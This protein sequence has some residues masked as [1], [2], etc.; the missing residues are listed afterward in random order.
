MRVLLVVFWLGCWSAFAQQPAPPPPAETT[1]AQEASPTADAR[2][3]EL[4]LIGKTNTAAGESRRNENVQFNLVDNNALKELN[5]RL[6]AT[7][8]IVK[9]SS[10]GARLLQRR[11]RQPAFAGAARSRFPR[12]ISW[13]S[14]GDAPEQHFQ[15]AIVFPGWRRQARAR[16]RLRLPC[17]R[18]ALARR[19]PVSGGRPEEGGR[20]RERQCARAQGRRTHSAHHR[21]GDPRHRR[22]FPGGLSGGASQSHRH[23]S[24]HV[25]HQLAADHRP[26]QRRR[27]AGPAPGHARPLE[28]ALPVHQPARGGV[29]TGGG[30]ESE[31][32]HPCPHRARHLGAPVEPGNH[33]GRLGGLRPDRRRCWRR[34][35]TRSARWFR[36]RGWNRSGRWR[37]SPS[38]GK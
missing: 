35:R 36:S 7:A 4:N 9:D 10:P 18:A 26:E 6:G 15:R 33:H 3:L 5:I 32:R 29:R 1:P 25:E 17:G 2:R 14:L 28:L 38:T 31:Q 24:A 12:R 8:T 34:R 37:P 13:R 11:I 30:P 27:A 16:E 23:Q 20:Q 21:P 19:G 22:A